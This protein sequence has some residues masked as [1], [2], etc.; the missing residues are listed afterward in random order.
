[1]NARTYGET[2]EDTYPIIIEPLLFYAV[3]EAMDRRNT[4]KTGRKGDEKISNHLAGNGLLRCECGSS[5]K[6]I[7][8]SRPHVK[9]EEAISGGACQANWFN[10]ERLE[11][12]LLSVLLLD[13]DEL[14]VRSPQADEPDPR[15]KLRAQIEE[16]KTKRTRL[17]AFIEDHD[18]LDD[19]IS[20]RLNLLK[21]EISERQES[22]RMCN[23]AAAAARAPDDA[24]ERNL[25]LFFEHYD[26]VQD[27]A[28]PEVLYNIRNRLQEALRTA[29]GSVTLVLG[30]WYREGDDEPMLCF[31]V[32]LKQAP[33]VA[34]QL[35]CKAPRQR[36]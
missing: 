32:R 30:N 26:A 19:D 12:E 17:L 28:N 5:V 7:Q 18:T 11:S 36:P 10:Y 2:K 14:S 31:E 21:R 20:E 13:S 33:D 9:C 4:V 16:R 29:I 15:P 8:G 35:L 25:L 24:A 3:G 23:A 6:F 34:L 1:M 22:L 27:G